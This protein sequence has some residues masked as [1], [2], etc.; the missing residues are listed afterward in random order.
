MY[1]V[2]RGLGQLVVDPDTGLTIDCSDWSNLLN[3]AC[4]G[5]SSQGV[6]A[7]IVTGAYAGN[8]PGAAA[9]DASTPGACGITNLFN[10][11]SN[12]TMSAGGILGSIAEVALIGGGVLVAIMVLGA[13]RR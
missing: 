12:C 3:L 10:G 7:P 2:R 9:G 1:G 4:Y 11:N 8:V 5:A 13:L 6:L